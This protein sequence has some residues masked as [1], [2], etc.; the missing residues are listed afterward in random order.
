MGDAPIKIYNSLTRQKEAFVPIQKNRID[1][2]VCGMTV[3][4]YCH[5]GHARVMVAFDAVIRYLRYRGYDVTYVRNITDIDDKIIKRANELGES[6]QSLTNRFIEYMNEDLDALSIVKPDHEPRATDYIPEIID[7]ISGLVEKGYAYP[8]DNGDV[9]YRPAKFENYGQL[10]GTRLEDL[11]VGARVEPG[12]AKEDPLD[13]VLWKSSKPDEPKWD[14][15]WGE[16]RPGWHIECSAM[17]TSLLGNHFDIHGGGLDLLFPHHENE[18]AQS[19]GVTGEKFVNLWMHN[20]YLQID[21]EKMSKSLGNFLT[22]REVLDTDDDRERIGEILRFVFLSSHYRSPLNYGDDSLD[23]AKMA[24]RRIYMAL[25]KAEEV[26][27]VEASEPDLGIIG[28]FHDAMDDDFNTPDG[29][30]VIFDCVRELNRAVESGPMRQVA[31]YRSTLQQLT[32]AL[33]LAQLSPARFLGVGGSSEDAIRI[34]ELIA[35]REQARRERS[36]DEADQIRGELT[37]MGVEIEDRPDGTTR[38]RK[39]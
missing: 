16:G 9:Y 22:I 32:S 37:A 28:R 4:D 14:S 23:N 30:A 15:P 36:W 2:Y 10:S 24:L 13:F 39:I 38:W 1:I 21:A 7:M 3:Y 8:A 25:Q 19:E 11:R 31:E 17:S 20:G 6:F 5:L 34:Q 29:L 18:I 27:A 33:G 26:G 12:E 35:R